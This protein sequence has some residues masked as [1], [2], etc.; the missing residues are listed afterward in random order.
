MLFTEGSV[1][2]GI[3]SVGRDVIERAGRADDGREYNSNCCVNSRKSKVVEDLVILKMMEMER[4]R[5][6]KKGVLILG[7]KR[8]R[9]G[10]Q[11]ENCILPV[12]NDCD[13]SHFANC[14]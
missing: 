4:Q 13:R 8:K 5:G 10:E 6:G 2:T 14:G 9:T 12:T 3:G 1:C 11:Q 7:T